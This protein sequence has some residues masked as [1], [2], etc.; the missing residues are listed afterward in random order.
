MND[1]IERQQEIKAP[2]SR[3]WRALADHREFGDWFRVKLTAPF[4]IGQVSTGHVTYPGFEH[5]PWKTIIQQIEPE[6]LFSFTWHPHAIETSVDYSEEATTLVEFR[7]EPTLEGTLLSVTE[8]GFS[9]LPLHRRDEAMSKNKTGWR[10]QMEN[11]AR[12]ISSH[13]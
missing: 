2:V 10:E 8:S 4:Q 12:H 5:V 9:E 11:I 13:P 1:R 7:L 3:V 6:R